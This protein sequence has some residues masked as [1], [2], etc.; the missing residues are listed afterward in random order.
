MPQAPALAIERAIAL[1]ASPYISLDE[2]PPLGASNTMP[3]PEV[4]TW[5]TELNAGKKATIEK[6]LRKAAGSRAEAA[7]LLDLNPKYFS[8]LC[9][10][11]N[12]KE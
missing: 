8:A 5:T 12:V 10:E 7:R 3:A 6:A 1:G 11:L 9:K 2:V 4:G